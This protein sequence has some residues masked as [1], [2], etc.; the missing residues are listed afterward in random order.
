MVYLCYLK[1]RI[2]YR[3]LQNL[4]RILCKN[5]QKVLK[6]GCLEYKVLI[7]IYLP[8]KIYSVVNRLYPSA[9]YI[10]KYSRFINNLAKSFKFL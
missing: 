4:I 7:L 5:F 6:I 9:K 2:F 10:K 8:T 1:I 3:L